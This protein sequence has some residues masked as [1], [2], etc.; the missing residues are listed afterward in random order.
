MSNDSTYQT[1]IAAGCCDFCG[2]LSEPSDG[3][4]A[5]SCNFAALDGGDR[6]DQVYGA[7]ECWNF[8]KQRADK[9]YSS[10]DQ[11]DYATILRSEYF[12]G[13]GNSQ[14]ESV[15]S[16]ER[17]AAIWEELQALRIRDQYDG[18]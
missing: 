2:L 5:C 3:D 14:H 8:G 15:C 1:I 12:G 6:D 17:K 7:I 10:G 9:K 4:P 11:D 13:P 16:E 18:V